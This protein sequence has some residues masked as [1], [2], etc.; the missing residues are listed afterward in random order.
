[1]ALSETTIVWIHYVAMAV[2][3][4]FDLAVVIYYAF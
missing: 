1:M 3:I 4:T 2:V